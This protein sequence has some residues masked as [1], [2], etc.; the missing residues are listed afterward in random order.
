MAHPRMDDATYLTSLLTEWGAPANLQAL[1]TAGGFSTLATVA[2]A[3]AEGADEATL[4]RALLR[5]TDDPLPVTPLVANARR[6]IHFATAAAGRVPAPSAAASAAPTLA[7]PSGPKL[8]A[9]MAKDLRAKSL[10]HYPGE[11]L[12]PDTTPSLHFL[13][14]LRSCLD[15]KG[16]LWV[17]WRLR[18]SEADALRWQESRRPRTDKQL[19]SL[20]LSDDDSSG[21]SAVVS[22]SGPAEPTLRRMLCILA[23]AL[24]LLGEAHLLAVRRF[25]E[26]F[27]SYALAQHQDPALRG[28]TLQEILSAHKAPMTNI[29]LFPGS[30]TTL[31]RGRSNKRL[32]ASP[33]AQDG[34]CQGTLC[35]SLAGC[36]ITA[37]AFCMPP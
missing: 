3:S 26:R 34:I 32:H 9:E 11:L 33:G 7:L 22:L 12:S 13:Q 35:P 31:R 37:R 16:L 15:D 25:N 17:P 20:L 14:H 1:L 10:T 8:T 19:L 27:L 30:A 6:L 2:F 21:P 4:I 5:I 36:S 29:C 18:S 23:V 28:P 24:A